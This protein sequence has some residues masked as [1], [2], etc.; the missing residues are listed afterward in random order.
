[1]L[2]MALLEKGIV[3]GSHYGLNESLS[4]NPSPN[5]STPTPTPPGNLGD[6]AH[7]DD[8]GVHL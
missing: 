5:L 4:T 8:D 7:A 3:A 1:M 6:Q 2:K